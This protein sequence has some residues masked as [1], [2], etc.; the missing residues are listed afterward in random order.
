LGTY[1]A[2]AYDSGRVFAI[3]QSGLLR[4]FDATTGNQVWTRQ[5]SAQSFTSPPTAMGG[6]VYVPGFSFLYAVSEQDGTI[7]WNAPTIIGDHSSPAV[8][9]GAVYLS[10]SCNQAYSFSPTTGAEIW[11]HSTMCAG[12]GGSTPVFYNGRVYIR[13]SVLANVVLD[14][15]IGL[16]VAEFSAGPAPAFHGSTGF[17]L[18]VSTLE[19]RDILSDAVKWS[20]TGDGN[21]SSAP[22]VVNG[23]VYIGSTSGKLYALDE[24]TGTNVW[25]GTVGAPVNRPDERNIS[26]PLTGLGAGEG[27]I[28]VPASNLV[29]AYQGAAASTPVVYVEEGT[30]NAVALDSVTFVRGPFRLS[31]DLNLSSD[32]RTRIIILTS[33][34][35]LTQ[36]DLSDPTALVVE[37]SG[38]NLPVENVGTLSI[39]GLS[40]SYVVVRLPDN[41]PTGALNLKIKLRGVV[42]NTTTLT[43]SP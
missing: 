36:S 16:A 8:T 43:I 24:S 29:V 40:S 5:L 30:N 19:A 41:I 1:P 6:T 17:Y 14:S 33:N 21:L 25:T 27:L 22:I 10:Y 31:N 37:A 20:F 23:V 28:V 26:V 4:A 34:L 39:P 15:G 3:N 42:S 12:G 35:G 13:D 7:K 2:I 18:N 32:Q 38:V 11:H 9:A